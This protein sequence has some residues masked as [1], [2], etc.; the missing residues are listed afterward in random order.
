MTV[1]LGVW[2][3]QT[4]RPIPANARITI[5]P[6]VRLRDVLVMTF[7][8]CCG[9]E[10]RR[11]LECGNA[12]L[13]GEHPRERSRN[14]RSRWSTCD[15]PAFPPRKPLTHQR[16]LTSGERP[17]HPLVTL[18]LGPGPEWAH[19][20]TIRVNHRSEQQVADLVGNRH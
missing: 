8:L 12:G 18:E 15:T 6:T 4:A 9:Q 13:Q 2:S 1:E 17:V 10:G 16:R 19:Q 5:T 11:I 20:S 3:A 7:P 14:D